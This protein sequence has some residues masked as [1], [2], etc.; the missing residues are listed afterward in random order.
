MNLLTGKQLKEKGILTKSP[1]TLINSD[2][3]LVLIL[4]KTLQRT[5]HG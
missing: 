4:W 5:L 3:D 2:H 1:P